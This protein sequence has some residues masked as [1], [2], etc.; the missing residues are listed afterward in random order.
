MK[1]I[2]L[3]SSSGGHFEQLLI[4]KKE[5]QSK[6]TVDVLTEKTKYSKPEDA[7]F[8]LFQVSRHDP[9]FFFKY[10]INFFKS[11][12]IVKILRP[13]VVISFGAL[14]TIPVCKIAKRRHIR[15][16]FIESF[17][18]INT[19]TKTGKYLYKYADEFVVQW[20]EMLNIYHKAHY[21]GGIY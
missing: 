13:D 16:I 8:F 1:K 21:F 19:P 18:K 6:Y 3:V 14:S 2:L 15:L 20:P 4:L 9:F 5:L 10:I 17:A 11:K 12:K 7:S